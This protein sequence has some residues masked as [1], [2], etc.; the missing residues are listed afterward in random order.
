MR[1]REA[2]SHSFLWLIYGLPT[3]EQFLP[4]L[5][6]AEKAGATPVRRGRGEGEARR[7]R[8]KAALF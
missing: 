4:S 3:T 7:K 5:V 2:V 1:T 6:R 8:E